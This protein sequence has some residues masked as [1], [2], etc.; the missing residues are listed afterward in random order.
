VLDQRRFPANRRLGNARL[1]EGGGRER[2]EREKEKERESENVREGELE[3]AR[4]MKEGKKE[5]VHD[6]SARTGWRERGRRMRE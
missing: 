6:R 2:R 5:G 4:D 3:R 1:E